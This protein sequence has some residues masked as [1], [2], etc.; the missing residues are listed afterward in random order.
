MSYESENTLLKGISLKDVMDLLESLD[1]VRIYHPKIKADDEIAQ[2]WWYERKDDQS[3]CVVELSI[4]KQKET[5]IILNETIKDRDFLMPYTTSILDK[6]ENRYIKNPKKIYS[7]YMAITF[8]SKPRARKE[9]NA[10][11]HPYDFTIRPQIVTKEYNED[12]YDI[13]T[14]F[15]KLSGIERI[16]ALKEKVF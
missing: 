12:Y 10:A 3:W 5:I 6:F 16:K 1:Y 7:P 11:I 13:I 14:K 8:N 4:F 9:I 15:Q 2:F